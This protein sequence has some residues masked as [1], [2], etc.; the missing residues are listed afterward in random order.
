MKQVTANRGMRRDVLYCPLPIFSIS[1]ESSRSSSSIGHFESENSN[2]YLLNHYMR[3]GTVQV[4][5]TMR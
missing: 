3:L 4:V 5:I 1:K 2:I